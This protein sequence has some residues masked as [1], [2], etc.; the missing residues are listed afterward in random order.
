MKVLHYKMKGSSRGGLEEEK[1]TKHKNKQKKM[2]DMNPFISIIMLNVNGLK[3]PIK[4]QRLPDSILKSMIRSTW[5]AQ[6]VKCLTS[7]QVM[8]SRFMGLNPV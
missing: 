3:N 2:A 7:S 1:D 6:S 5:V 4:S 8:I